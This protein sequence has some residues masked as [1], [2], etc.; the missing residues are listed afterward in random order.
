[1]RQCELQ[2]PSFGLDAAI[3]DFTSL[4]R[5]HPDNPS[6]HYSRGL[7]YAA[8][9]DDELASADFDRAKQLGY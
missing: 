2:E 8:W 5:L 4:L 7:P 1:M 3:D 9:N 6:V